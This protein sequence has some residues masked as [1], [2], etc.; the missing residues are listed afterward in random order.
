[1]IKNKEFIYIPSFSVGA[2]ASALT[3][4]Y[5]L[6]DTL[7]VRF[8]SDEFPSFLR[9]NS[10]LLTAGHLYKKVNAAEQF[11]LDKDK[12]LILGDSGGFQFATGALK[13]DSS[14]REKL[15]IWLENNSTV[16]MNL[17]I[18]PRLKN[19]GK[20]NE[21]LKISTENFKYFHENQTGK[22]KFLNVLQG[23][24]ELTYKSWYDAVKNFD[25]N[26]WAI[27][28]A[29]G[30][31]Y[32]LLSAISILLDGKE[33]LKNQ[34]QFLHILGSSRI[35]DFYILSQLQKSL[36]EVDSSFQVMTDS[37]SPSL[38]VA[39][40]TYFINADIQKCVFRTINIPKGKQHILDNKMFIPKTQFF[41][42]IF[43][44]IITEQDIFD[45]NEKVVCIMTLHNFLTFKQGIS[46]VNE[47]VYN[48]P[49][50]VE[51]SVE[52]TLFS[53][54][55]SIDE[56]V[57]SEDPLKVFNKYRPAYIKASKLYDVTDEFAI[58]TFFDF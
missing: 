9:H 5:K 1:M 58:N 23:T 55:K 47:L 26:G 41:D 53:V 4:N 3:K 34:N 37:S 6:T 17:D 19:S 50:L 43:N 14:F 44:N 16:A 8:Y 51:E 57:K 45:F 29:G 30:K 35:S 36:N 52:S 21:C 40:G 20:F 25:F 56:M 46:M 10:F 18:P 11:G 13:W 32:N 28:G 12:H 22:T 38:S 49:Y 15:F 39:F 7:P 42:V 54:I 33:H 24:D 48:D 2:F 27:G 31:L